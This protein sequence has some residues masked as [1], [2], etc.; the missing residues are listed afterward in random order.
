M[1]TIWNTRKLIEAAVVITV[2]I[3]FFMPS[4]A[5]FTN[6]EIIG[7]NIQNTSN[8]YKIS[9]VNKLHPNPKP[10]SRGE[11]VLVSWDNPD[12]D[13]EKPKIRLSELKQIKE[14]E[15]YRKAK[16]EIS[17]ERTVKL[18]GILERWRGNIEQR[19]VGVS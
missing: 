9:A 8:F 2:V 5:V 19:R 12:E 7:K 4:S 11:D 13:D 6:N 14:A 1:N 3:G 18:I 15:E 10:L 17:K 16:E